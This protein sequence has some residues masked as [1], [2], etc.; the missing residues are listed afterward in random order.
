MLLPNRVVNQVEFVTL[1]NVDQFL[2]GSAF[3]GSVF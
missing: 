2:G 1:E 3:G